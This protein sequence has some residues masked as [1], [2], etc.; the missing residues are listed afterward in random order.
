MDE[1]AEKLDNLDK[2]E[3]TPNSGDQK[4]FSRNLGAFLIGLVVTLS[5]M[6]GLEIGAS[7]L[8]LDLIDGIFKFWETHSIIFFLIV[9]LLSLSL[10]GFATG[11]IIRHEAGRYGIFVGLPVVLIYHFLAVTQAL[12]PDA[13]T[14]VLIIELLAAFI[15][16]FFASRLGARYG[17]RIK[18]HEDDEVGTFIRIPWRKWVWFWIP[19]Q[20]AFANLIVYFYAI[21][22]DLYAGWYF[23]FNPD[24]AKIYEWQFYLMFIGFFT[25]IPIG[26]AM[27][28]MYKGIESIQ[29]DSDKVWWKQL[30][31]FV[32]Y[33]LIIPTI[34][35]VINIPFINYVEGLLV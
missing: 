35:T 26:A 22:V 18:D 33:F 25:L 17:N 15:V 24:V 4:V 9:Y 5:V 13:H 28:S 31:L 10:G 30:L 6:N 11:Y 14:I 32:L 8:S 16:G 27:F 23:L 3:E 29:V 12:D 34:L 19:L 20:Y 21:L 1:T 7:F 2:K